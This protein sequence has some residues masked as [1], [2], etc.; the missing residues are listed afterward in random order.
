MYLKSLFFLQDKYP[1]KKAYPFN[2]SAINK[3]N[4]I[5]FFHNVCFFVGENGS[6]KSTLLEAIAYN[7]GFN[8]EGGNRNTIYELSS[9]ESDLGE[10]IKLSWSPKITSGFFLRAE[11][12]F[13]FASYLESM[14][15]G[16][17][18]YGGTSL[19]KQSHGEAFFSLF[20]NR[21]MGK[22]IYLLDEPEA[23]LSP[24]RQL[25]F[26]RIINEMETTGQAQ[27]IIATH[28]PILLAY[29]GAQILNFDLSPLEQ[30][31]YENC[32]PYQITRGFLENRENYL[33]ELFND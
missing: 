18:P 20:N 31:K 5:N 30:I 7:C 2:I 8:T 28:S 27:F 32:S 4:T 3:L 16:L 6:G 22:G 29:P 21:F 9:S 17:I 25:A 33:K 13:N 15:N 11:S 24:L 23:A 14:P 26:L 12:F 10:Y 1:S 19:H